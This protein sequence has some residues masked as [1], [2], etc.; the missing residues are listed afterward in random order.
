MTKDILIVVRHGPYGGFQAAEGLRHASGAISLGFRPIFI[1]V[2]DGVYL[3]KEGQD[4]GKSEW[5]ELD[6]TL[7]EV[8][9]RGLYEMKDTPAEFYVE[10][11]SLVKR[12]LDFEELVEG[13]E[14]IDHQKVSEFMAANRLQLIF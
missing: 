5:L 8:I 10:N 2:D 1:L 12:G 6:G 7:E 4:P 13:L 3:A 11:E 9:A 14:P